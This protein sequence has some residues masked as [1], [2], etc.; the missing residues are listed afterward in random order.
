LLVW[1]ICFQCI[2]SPKTSHTNP[3]KK[4]YQNTDLIGKLLFVV[5]IAS[6]VVGELGFYQKFYWWDL[7]LHFVAGICF[8][9]IGVGI[10]KCAPHLKLGHMLTF[11]F[12][13]SL[14][15][16][17]IWEL[18]EFGCDLIFNWNMQRWHYHPDYP[19]SYGRIINERTPGVIDTMTDV[20]ANILGTVLM[21]GGYFVSNRLRK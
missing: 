2:K 19:D 17:V 4:I 20:I 18:L 3:M 6:A 14:S 11:A 15:I 7:L 16:H 21:C 13:F 10:A 5:I 1:R 9:S 8:V 12:M